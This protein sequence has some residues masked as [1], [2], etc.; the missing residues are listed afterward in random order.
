MFSDLFF[1]AFP[2]VSPSRPTFW[3]QR[4]PQVVGHP[5]RH[6]VLNVYINI[7]VDRQDPIVIKFLHVQEEDPGQKHR[8]GWLDDLP[9]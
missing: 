8:N 9:G 1:N 2:S 6:M 7:L 5:M 3:S 4:H